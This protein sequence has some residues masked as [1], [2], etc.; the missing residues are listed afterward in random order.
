MDEFP[1]FIKIVIGLIVGVLWIIGKIAENKKKP[2][3]EEPWVPDES[4]DPNEPW[5]EEPR[6]RPVP[7]TFSAP[8]PL[9]KFIPA[10]E[11][12]LA[13]Q[14]AMQEK[15]AELRRAPKPRAPVRP[16]AVTSAPVTGPSGLG[17]RL[18]NRGE[19]RR[20]FVIKEILDPPVGLR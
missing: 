13:R 18:R 6:H 7:P 9:P 1:D 12:E 2:Q 10:E 14:Q 20:A 8:P 3:E 15:L 17:R 16:R 19:L 11:G 5:E 4:Y